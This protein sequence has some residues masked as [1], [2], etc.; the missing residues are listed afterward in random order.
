MCRNINV[1]YENWKPNTGYKANLLKL[2]SRAVSAYV[3]ST[4]LREV[5]SLTVRGQPDLQS[6][7]QTSQGRLESLKNK[8]K[9]SIQL[10]MVNQLFSPGR[11]N[12][13]QL[14]V[15]FK[16]CFKWCLDCKNILRNWQ[17]LRSNQIVIH[18]FLDEHYPEAMEP[19]LQLFRHL[20]R[21]SVCG[22]RFRV[23]SLSACRLLPE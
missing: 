5:R 14:S 12:S 10:L 17:E 6:E 20:Q 7:F 1:Y 9:Q 11:R 13:C 22:C 8:R 15:G 21:H 16:S 3:F 18:V 19:N 23:H 4:S 2:Y